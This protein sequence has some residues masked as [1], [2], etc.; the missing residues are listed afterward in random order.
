MFIRIP[1]FALLLA[2]LAFSAVGSDDWPGEAGHHEAVKNLPGRDFENA[3]TAGVPLCIYF[4]DPMV[5]PNNRAR[6]LEPVLGN[7]DLRAKMKD[8]LWL[9]IRTDGTDVRGWPADFRDPAN[10]SASFVLISSDFKQIVSFDK[11][12]QANQITTESIAG[13]VDNMLQYEKRLVLLGGGKTA[14]GSAKKEDPK[15]TPV[16]EAAK[17]P[18]LNDKDKKPA[19][20][21]AKR[22]PATAA[23]E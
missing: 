19:A 6:Y 1:A 23:D 9:K 21:A 10:K 2:T 20:T 18:G 12:M 3:R 4:F 15:V 14:A 13:A 5:R 17:V 16:I 7:L 22:K 8:F 11:N